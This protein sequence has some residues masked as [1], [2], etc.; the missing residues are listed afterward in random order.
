[1]Q[2]LLRYNADISLADKLGKTPLLLAKSDLIDAM[3]QENPN[4]KS[5][6]RVCNFHSMYSTDHTLL[7]EERINEIKS[8]MQYRLFQDSTSAAQEQE[9]GQRRDHPDLQYGI[10]SSNIIYVILLELIHGFKDFGDDFCL[11]V[12]TM[13]SVVA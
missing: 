8:A 6:Y 13:K 3:F 12:F 2:L 7:N 10:G 1:M 4:R 11:K 5:F 9:D